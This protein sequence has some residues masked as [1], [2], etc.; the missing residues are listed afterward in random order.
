[1]PS[2]SLPS[3]SGRPMGTEPRPADA[4]TREDPPVVHVGPYMKLDMREYAGIPLV[5]DPDFEK[6][7]GDAPFVFVEPK[8]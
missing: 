1:M 6:K 5:F 2:V 3:R 8:Y 7:Y 4:E